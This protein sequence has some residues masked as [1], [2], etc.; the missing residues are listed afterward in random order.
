MLISNLTGNML[1]SQLP[2][3]L[4]GLMFSTPK[5]L[6]FKFCLINFPPRI[7][8]FKYFLTFTGRLRVILWHTKK[9]HNVAF[10]S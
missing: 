7:P 3:D 5:G 1:P 4:I 8:F 6:F 9:C 10:F 2:V